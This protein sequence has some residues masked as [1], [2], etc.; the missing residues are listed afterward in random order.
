M[1]EQEKEGELGTRSLEFEYLHQKSRWKIMLIGRDDISN[2]VITLST[3]FSMF[4]YI[5]TCFRFTLIGENLTVDGEPQGNWRW[6]SNSRDIVAS[7]PSFSHP[8]AVSPRRAYSQARS[9]F[10]S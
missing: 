5:C 7:S 6:N 2:S 1:A 10:P 8:I 4:V 3:W 9:L